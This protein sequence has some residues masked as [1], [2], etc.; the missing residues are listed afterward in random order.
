MT[1]PTSFVPMRDALDAVLLNGAGVSPYIIPAGTFDE[2]WFYENRTLV[3]LSMDTL[4]KPGIRVKFDYMDAKNGPL[5]P[6]SMYKY[7]VSLLIQFAFKLESKI[8]V[9]RRTEVEM[10]ILDYSRLVMKALQFPQNLRYDPDNNPTGLASGRFTY[11]KTSAIKYDYE[12]GVAT[13]DMT[14]SGI[15]WLSND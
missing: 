12:L 6:S 1:T 9:A 10:Q 11:E 14:F 5:Q 2:R 4:V 13:K 7:N 3:G 15:V 8:L